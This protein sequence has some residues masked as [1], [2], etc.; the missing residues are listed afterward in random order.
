M[1]RA[2][3]PTSIAMLVVFLLAGVAQAAVILDENNA[4]LLGTAA[5]SYL[6]GATPD[7]GSSSNVIMLPPSI[8]GSE[9]GSATWT[10]S[11]APGKKY[12]VTARRQVEYNS[13]DLQYKIEI[14]GV[15]YVHDWAAS[16]YEWD[17]DKFR[18]QTFLGYYTPTGS[19]TT[20]RVYDPGTMT[21]KLD[22][23][24]FEAANDVYFDENVAGLTF[25]G[26]SYPINVAPASPTSYSS[27]PVSQPNAVY[28]DDNAAGNPG[29][30][31][32]TVS[33]EA[34]AT[35]DVYASRVVDQNWAV[36]SY[37]IGL[38]GAE[39]TY[40]LAWTSDPALSE[41]V[42]ETFLGHFVPSGSAT[43]V[44][45]YWPGSSAATVDYIRFEKQIKPTIVL[46]ESNVTLSGT[47]SA[48]YYSQNATP[49]DGF[50]P[51]YIYLESTGIADWAATVEPNQKYK[52]T[53]RRTVLYNNELRST[54]SFDDVQYMT[55]LA[56]TMDPVMWD[57]MDTCTFLG[58]FSTSD[59]STAVNVTGGPWGA[60]I[61]WIK[62]VPTDDVYFDE[63]T[64]DLAFEN[65]ASL[66][67]FSTVGSWPD[68]PGT[69]PIAGPNGIH[70]DSGSGTP[71]ATGTVTLIPGAVYR[72]FSSR[73]VH[74]NNNR[75]FDVY[76]N[77]HLFARDNALPTEYVIEQ[78]PDTGEDITRYLHEDFVEEDYLGEY[79]VETS[80][81]QIEIDNPA[82]W[83]SRSDYIRFELAYLPVSAASLAEAKAM[84]VG[85]RVSISQPVVATAGS[86]TFA[87]GSYY[88][89]DTTRAAGLKIVPDDAVTTT[90]TD[91]D[92]VTMIGD[93]GID[94]NGEKYLKAI[95]VTAVSGTPLGP[96]GV[97]NKT[98]SAAT[99]LKPSALLI[100]VWGKVVTDTSD[101]I[102]VDDGS[103]SPVMVQLSGLTT[104]LTK[105][106]AFNDYVTVT[107]I[108]ACGAGGTTVI[109]PRDDVD[110][111]NFTNP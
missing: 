35:Y 98:V 108:A 80:A 87:D 29:G 58:Y 33:L 5:T 19:T 10:T 45:L 83:A 9:A 20:V 69:L 97:T 70:M 26:N 60:Q 17:H 54:I 31:T 77:G 59:A 39:F 43:T 64:A 91:G 7:N 86:A 41:T 101:Y 102:E 14:D 73:Q 23:I 109:L 22:Y 12:R 106:P 63:N 92:R 88:V 53:M 25:G 75:G 44:S 4:T 79:T 30:V 107:G 13:S 105:D 21:A 56:Y 65:N 93:I 62:L 99:G 72:V 48:L 81:T 18:D 6:A 100:K 46:D 42:Q 34:G 103:G 74:S 36:R 38:G 66:F 89:E 55:D 61:D 11:L 104:P 37:F 85:T 24:R 2:V 28:F 49:N 110:I 94:G 51:N 27:L 71:S 3:L 67:T 32:G 95:S 96:L 15:F 111:I 1:N 47:G 84:G 8:E 16:R 50:T 90:V 68:N 52:L 76:F 40:D 82:P 57:L 78:D